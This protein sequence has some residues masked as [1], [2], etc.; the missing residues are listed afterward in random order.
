MD[1]TTHRISKALEEK[2]V[3]AKGWYDRRAALIAGIRLCG[4]IAERNQEDRDAI[5][6]E[7]ASILE[8]IVEEIEQTW[9]FE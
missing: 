8:E 1:D 2:L 9:G 6:R 3:E 5:D 4:G 7:A